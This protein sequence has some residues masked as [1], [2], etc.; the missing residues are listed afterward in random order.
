[1]RTRVAEEVRKAG[2][3]FYRATSHSLYFLT[4]LQI[5]MEEV[6]GG[7]VSILVG[8]GKGYPLSP[9]QLHFT[10]SFSKPSLKD[11]RDIMVE[12]M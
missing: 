9:P 1:M 11:Y 7:T 6:E 5:V 12:L 2:L 4:Q 3:T 10:S 8:L